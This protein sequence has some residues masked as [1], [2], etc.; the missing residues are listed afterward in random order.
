LGRFIQPDPIVPGIGEGGNP[1][2]VGYLDASTYSPLTVD[3][4]EIQILEQLNQ[5]NNTRLQDPN[6]ILP[7]VPPNSI[8]FDRYAYSLNNPVRYVDP[9]GHNPLAPVFALIPL[10]TV[11][12]IA[13]TAVVLYFAVP[14]V[15]EAVT[16][17]IEKAGEAAWEGISTVFAKAKNKPK[18]N[19]LQT[20][21]HTI[22]ERTR[23]GLGL[24]KEEAQ[25]A[26]EDLKTDT[27]YSKDAHL[28]IF[29]D[30]SVYDPVTDEVIGNMNDYV[31]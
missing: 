28:Q 27:G 7:P 2:A 17:N 20:G 14:G 4:H 15:R 6:F 8:A 10:V 24:T 23:K 9:N 29:E 12:T 22:T 26:I 21:G 18:G 31:P 1:D 3:Y 19:V 25:R 30:G 11:T 13:I 16:A 5:E